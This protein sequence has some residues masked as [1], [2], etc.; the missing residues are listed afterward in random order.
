LK[1][2]RRFLWSG[3]FALSIACADAAED[4]DR[5]P[6]LVK[7]V[8]VWSPDRVQVNNDV[9][10]IDGRIA[11]ISRS[12]RIK[13]PATAR[14]IE[15]KGTIM[16]PG[17]IDA[18]VHFVYG[19]KGT[20]GPDDHRWG[21]AAVTG[22]QT[23]RAGVTSARLH[24][25][26]LKNGAMLHADSQDD[27]AP[28]PRLQ[29]GG[30][31]FIPG[32]PT[33]DRLPVWGVTGPDD[34]AAKVRRLKDSG[35]DWI[36]IHEA[37]KFSPPER[38]A[39]V[40]TARALGLRI[41][42][43][44]YTQSELAASLAL[45]PD[46]IDYIDVSA[47]PEYD[48][49]LLELARQQRDLVW[50]ARL[51]IHARFRAYQE[52]P[53]LIDDPLNYELMSKEEAEVLRTSIHEAVADRSSSNSRRMDE[54]YP[55]LRRKFAQLRA[56]GIPLA[57][58]TDAGSPAHF[59]RDAIWWELRAWVQNGATV[60]EA[61]RAATV[62]GAKALRDESIGTLKEGARADFLLFRGKLTE[63]RLDARRV[64][65]VVKGGVVHPVDGE[66]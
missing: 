33:H 6:L 2:V 20:S 28:L 41:L 27:C 23:L 25:A 65:R 48:P 9:L 8:D 58:G 47:Q 57:A 66:P 49:Q 38:D 5:S 16:L 17:F 4:C 24:L 13:P 55:T 32:S 59:H 14:I 37:Q 10:V 42:G 56:S 54:A 45:A 12:G 44:G 39:I 61:L 52:N 3:L 34:A 40:G 63:G 31:A 7:H 62:N 51:G 26:E 50:V 29:A 43:S 19:G 1:S 21:D 15:G 30:P 18:H 22:P 35:F 53:K 11:R 46:T 64:E 36:A 60:T